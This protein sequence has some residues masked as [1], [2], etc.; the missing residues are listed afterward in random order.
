MEHCLIDTVFNCYMISLLSLSHSLKPSAGFLFESLF[1]HTRLSQS[2][3]P[4]L[5]LK[6]LLKLVEL[7]LA[8]GSGMHKQSD[9]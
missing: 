6:L 7:T 9:T 8:K 1:V 2:T 3:L 5:E 4:V